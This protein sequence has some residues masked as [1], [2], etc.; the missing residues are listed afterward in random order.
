MSVVPA[1]TVTQ[2]RKRGRKKDKGKDGQDTN[3]KSGTAA[4]F[5]HSQKKTGHMASSKYGEDKIKRIVKEK[6]FQHIKFVTDNELEAQFEDT[7]AGGEGFRKMIELMKLEKFTKD[8]ILEWWI[9]KG[10]KRY[11]R[12]AIHA[13]RNYADQ[14]IGKKVDGKYHV[15]CMVCKCN[16]A[17]ALN[18]MLFPCKISEVYAAGKMPDSFAKFKKLRKDPKW[19]EVLCDNFVPGVIGKKEW[20]RHKIAHQVSDKVTVTD[21][22]L[23]LTILENKWDYWKA[24]AKIV[25]EEKERD[26]KAKKLLENK[27]KQGQNPASQT[28]GSNAPPDKQLEE[29]EIHDEE[30]VS[31]EDE[32]V[33]EDDRNPR[34]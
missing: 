16:Y 27:E 8:E 30:E 4:D 3:L 22:G 1:V 19:F 6:L 5:E 9:D 11:T 17:M 32:S 24:R 25:R 13:C 31:S 23:V 21:I 2:D 33:D 34:E 12:K 14:E 7:V 15:Q 18:W 10:A 20:E 26:E 29:E 28:G